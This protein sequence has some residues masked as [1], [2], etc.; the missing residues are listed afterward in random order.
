MVTTNNKS[1]ITEKPVWFITSCSTG[2][3]RELAKHLLDRGYRVS[4]HVS[5]TRYLK[6]TPLGS[7]R[8]ARLHRYYRRLRLPMASASFLAV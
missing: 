4:G 2:F 5:I 3:G 1:A 8:I 6:P 7:I